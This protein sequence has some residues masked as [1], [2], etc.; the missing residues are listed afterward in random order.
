MNVRVQ[1]VR[2][3]ARFRQIVARNPAIVALNFLEGAHN[4]QKIIFN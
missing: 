2:I 4:S 3:V 1:K